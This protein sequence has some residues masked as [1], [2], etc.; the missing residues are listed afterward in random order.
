MLIRGEHAV[1]ASEPAGL[2]RCMPS[3]AEAGSTSSPLLPVHTHP[4][5]K[6]AKRAYV[7]RGDRVEKSLPTE[8]HPSFSRWRG[9][10]CCCTMSSRFAIRLQTARAHLEGFGGVQL[11]SRIAHRS[12]FCVVGVACALLGALRV[13]LRESRRSR[14]IGR[15]N[16]LVCPVGLSRRASL[17]PR[18]RP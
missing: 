1:R 6:S 15:S 7:C 14:S 11:T 8:W 13:Q 3:L 17:S 9:F 4:S 12:R 16:L 2:S 5:P 18:L 10:C